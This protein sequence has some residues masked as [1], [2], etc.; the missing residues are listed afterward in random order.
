M[1]TFNNSGLLVPDNRIGSNLK[2]IESVFVTDIASK[3]RIELFEK[4]G[5]YNN[6]LKNKCELSEFHQWIDGSFVTKKRNPG[7]IDLITFINSEKLEQIGN[8]IDDFKYPNS[9]NKFGVD[10]YIVESIQIYISTKF[11]LF[12]I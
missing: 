2:E 9:E 11:L 5:T 7:D 10:A 4:L 6:Q 1:L 12:S 8:K 3:K